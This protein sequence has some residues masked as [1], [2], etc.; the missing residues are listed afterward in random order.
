MRIIGNALNGD[1]FENLVSLAMRADSGLQ[2]ISL[3]VAWVKSM[4]RLFEL[5]MAK[6]VPLTL[7]ALAEDGYPATQVVQR[8]ID[9]P[10]TWQLFLTRRFYHPK[11]VW[12][13][14]V[15]VYIGSANLTTAGWWDNL[16]CGVWFSQDEIDR[17]NLEAQLTAMFAVIAKRSTGVT[18]EHLDAFRRLDAERA[19]LTAAE[20][21]F[22]ARVDKEFANL[23][24]QSKPIRLTAKRGGARQQFIADWQ[25]GLE[26]LRKIVVEAKRRTW[27]AWV[28]KDTNPAVVQDQAT[29]YW[30]HHNIRISGDSVEAIEA[31]HR[32]NRSDP[33]AALD[34]VFAEWQAFGGDEKW[35]YFVNEAP[36]RVG[37]LLQRPALDELDEGRLTDILHATHAA[38]EH[39]RQMR[40]KDLGD[41]GTTSTSKER[42]R[43]FA[44]YLLGQESAGGKSVRDVLH[45]VIWGDVQTPDI[46]ER[47]W[48]AAHEDEWKLP[49]LGPSIL[50]EMV[51][52]ARPDT[53]PPRNGRVSKTLAA[54]GYEGVLY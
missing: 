23:A 13:R 54:L 28:D 52:Y 21:A 18:R 29:E 3:A 6:N 36:R 22:Q 20:R 9:G 39:A 34:Q 17:N 30:Y 38:R 46:G 50:G 12:F 51:G 42:S 44:R 37:Q 1:Y 41:E 40:K 19:E 24:G 32:K 43:L 10:T 47:I 11:V 45:Y 2:Q 15:G 7:Y 26:L 31:F 5:T 53:Y 33:A 4:D 16:E 27:P 8:F 35:A 48:D 14:G 25:N 49:H